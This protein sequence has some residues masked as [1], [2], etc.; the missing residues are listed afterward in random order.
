MESGRARQCFST[1]GGVFL[2]AYQLI[3]VHTYIH[4]RMS[5]AK[6][7]HKH[8]YEEGENFGEPATVVR[9]A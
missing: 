7:L 9:L 5:C 4:V 8:I 1:Y 2:L 3:F 6:V